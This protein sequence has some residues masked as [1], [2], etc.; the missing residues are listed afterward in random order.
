MTSTPVNWHEDVALDPAKEY[1]ALVRSL[2]WTEGFGVLFVQCSV[3]KGNDLVKQV[4][5]DLA[6][7][8]IEVLALKAEDTNL[9]DCVAELPNL[10]EINVLFV[11]GLEHSI[12]AYEGS[13]AWDTPSQAYTYSE[14]SVPRLLSHLNLNRELFY[15]QFKF[16]LVFLVP[17]FVLKYVSRRAPDFFDWRSGVLEFP[18]DAE[19]AQREY[20]RL[21]LSGHHN[22]YF[23]WTVARRIQRILE[24]QTWL[25]EP[26]ITLEGRANLLF[27]QALL[28]YASEKHEEAVASYDKALSIKPDFHEACYYRGVSL[29][30]LGH[31]EEA[32][33]SY[34]QVLTIKPDF[35]KAWYKRGVSLAAL[36]H[37]EEA[38][39]SYDQV[40]AIKPDFHEAWYSRGI[41]LAALGRNEEEIANYDKL[42]E[43]NPDYHAAW[44]S[45]G[46]SLYELGRNEEAI[47]NYDRA[48]ELKPDEHFYWHNRGVSLSVLGRKE[49]AI[50]D[51]DKALKIK[52]NKYDAWY[53]RGLTLTA[54]G[55]NEEAVASYDQVLTIKPDDHE[56]WYKRGV[57]LYHLGR[58]EDAIAS[59]DEALG[60]KP[61]Y[62]SA[63]FNKACCYAL[64]NQIDPALDCLQQSIALDPQWKEKA[65]TDT[66]F[67]LIR[68]SDRFRA[69]VEGD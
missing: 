11:Q 23:T 33:A 3:A 43:I 6:G 22:E 2:R 39:A 64:Q 48:L 12:Y 57:S 20:V 54:L 53:D 42:L 63:I 65:K 17:T 62:A 41:S 7:K 30:A 61:D 59:Y 4:R 25:D 35:H 24:I 27:E 51:Y 18:A 10:D 29:A 40:L 1:R 69:V 50:I 68:E 28:F 19:T 34:D 38:I 46:F 47:S 16:F 60:I 8:T 49:E 13:Q 15:K 31:F 67:D 55:R 32:I 26:E 21:Y 14:A 56:A 36:G 44:N 37:F 52:P 9:F 45:R 58:Y 5:Q 66:D